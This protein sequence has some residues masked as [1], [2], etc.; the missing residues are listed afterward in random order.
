MPAPV[1][2]KSEFWPLG[3]FGELLPP[4][5]RAVD[6]A[7][8]A[9]CSPPAVV[10]RWSRGGGAQEEPRFSHIAPPATHLHKTFNLPVKA[11]LRKKYKRPFQVQEIAYLVPIGV[12]QL[13][14]PPVFRIMVLA[15]S[16]RSD[17]ILLVIVIALFSLHANGGSS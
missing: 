6:W 2:T 1:I 3:S 15:L 4:R 13:L 10:V 7:V 17:Q 5:L 12:T 9:A 14:F 16:W 11:F 8:A